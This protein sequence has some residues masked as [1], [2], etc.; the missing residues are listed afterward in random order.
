MPKNGIAKRIFALA[1]EQFP[2][3]KDF[4]AAIGVTPSIVSQ[5]RTGITTSFRGRL[6]V[7]ASVL[8]TTADY[9]LTGEET[10]KPATESG[11]GQAEKLARALR[12]IGINVDKLS[13]AEISRIARLAKAALEE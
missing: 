11:D 5:W 1:D 2:E 10:E 12:D 3:Q 13:D 9:L 7:I 4:A 6:D 8:G